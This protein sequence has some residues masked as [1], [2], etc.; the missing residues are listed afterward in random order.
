MI[1]EAT[2]EPRLVEIEPSMRYN[3]F[4]TTISAPA[5]FRICQE[6]RNTVEKKYPLCFGSILQPPRIRVNFELDTI[7]LPAYLTEF[8]PHF[9]GLLNQQ[10]LSCIHRLAIDF[11]LHWDDEGPWA[12]GPDMH[13]L[14]AIKKA[15]VA[16]TGLKELVIVYEAVLMITDRRYDLDYPLGGMQLFDTFPQIRYSERKPRRALEHVALPDISGTYGTWGVPK[17]RAMY[18]W[19][20]QVW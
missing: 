12:R 5:A 17:T 10:E 3:G 11:R 19:S 7:F 13:L 2:L 9:L 1:W 16:M 20:G 4:L 6:S 8:M 18:G 15:V 14:Q